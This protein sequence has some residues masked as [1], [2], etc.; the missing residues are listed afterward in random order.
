MLPFVFGY[1]AALVSVPG[2]LAV[3]HCRMTA[4]FPRLVHIPVV[5]VQRAAKRGSQG[6]GWPGRLRG[7]RGLRKVRLQDGWGDGPHRRP[8]ARVQVQT[9]AATGADDRVTV[10]HKAGSAGP[11]AKNRCR[12]AAVSG[13]RNE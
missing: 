9:R 10:A 3:L 11:P 13:D 7:L 6:W 5:C 2:D 4:W 8:T 1:G 12:N